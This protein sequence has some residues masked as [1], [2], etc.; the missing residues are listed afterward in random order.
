MSLRKAVLVLVAVVATATVASS[1]HAQLAVY[2]TVTVNQMSGIKNSPLATFGPAGDINPIGGGG[3]VYYDFLRLGRVKLG[4]DLRS[5]LTS[6]KRGAY[7]SSD[8]SGARLY[9]TLGG[10]RAV[11]HTPFVPLRPYLQ[12]S[13]GL[14]RTDYGL[15]PLTNKNNFQYMGYAGIDITLLPVMDFRLVEF[16]YGGLNPMGTNSHNYPI[17][18]V[19]SGLVFHLPF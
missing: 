4:A 10:I 5:T 18:S 7:I 9:S 6:T 8:G 3:G 15:L 19:S 11:F 2:G 12:V 16:G 14:G 17:K 1:A 13:A